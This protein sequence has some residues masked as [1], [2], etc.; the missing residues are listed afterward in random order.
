MSV[1]AGGQLLRTRV[2]QNLITAQIQFIINQVNSLRNFDYIFL[3]ASTF[4]SKA[5]EC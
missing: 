5:F 4:S 1:A 2:R 3:E